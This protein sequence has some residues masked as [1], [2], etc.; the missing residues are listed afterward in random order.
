MNHQDSIKYW[1]QQLQRVDQEMRTWHQLQQ[2]RDK[3]LQ[4]IHL[5]ELELAQQ[6]AS[7]HPVS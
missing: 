2:Q 3:I 5:L 7:Q 1:E 4:Q 6:L